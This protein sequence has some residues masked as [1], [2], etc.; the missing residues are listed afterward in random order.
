[1][2]F[3][4]TVKLTIYETIAR[5][6]HVPSAGEVAQSLAAPPAEVAAAFGRLQW[7]DIIYT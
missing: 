3:D 4:T 2:D 5:S 7:D 1:M 6:A